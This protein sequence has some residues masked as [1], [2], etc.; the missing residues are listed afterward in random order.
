[1]TP[2]KENSESQMHPSKPPEVYVHSKHPLVSHVIR[3]TLC[4]DSLLRDSVRVLPRL[5]EVQRAT[6][7]HHIVIL[8]TC[9]VNNWAEFLTRCIPF[10]YRVIMLLA[11]E[12]ADCMGQASLLHLGVSGILTL[13]NDLEQEL[14]AAIHSVIQGKLWISR[15]TFQQYV[16]QTTSFLH[17]SARSHHAF[18]ARQEQIFSFII[19]GLSNRQ[20][21]TILGISE[22][23]VKFHVSNILQKK[24]VSNRQA[25]VKTSASKCG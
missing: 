18:T 12:L 1:M 11:P 13:S 14:I 10:G 3:R 5:W 7:Q 16:E 6:D 15:T 25:L 21:A 2:C 17:R 9:S 4:S 23:T 20:I 8:D 22:R 19:K 24:N